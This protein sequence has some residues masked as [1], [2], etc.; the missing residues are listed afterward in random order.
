MQEDTHKNYQRI[1]YNFLKFEEDA[2][3][4]FSDGDRTKRVLTNPSSIELPT[5]IVNNINDWKQSFKGV[6]IWLKGECLEI[7][8][9]MD[10]MKGREKL[11]EAQ[12]KSEERK[13]DKQ[14]ELDKMSMGKTT[15]KS[16]FKT[17]STI[18]KDILN[19]QADIE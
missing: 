18:E 16:F 1:Y 3:D 7:K 13:R 15:L 19:Y 14:T 4:F 2:L 6:W 17:K 11:I 12:Q 10:A 9:M 8:G 5:T